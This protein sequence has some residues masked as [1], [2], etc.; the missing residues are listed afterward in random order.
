MPSGGKREGAGA[1]KK[2]KKAKEST[3]MLTYDHR[4]WLRKIGCGA[5]HT[6][7]IRKLIDRFR[8]KQ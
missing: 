7:I 2:D 3:I 6:V 1:P 8:G 4:K 5:S